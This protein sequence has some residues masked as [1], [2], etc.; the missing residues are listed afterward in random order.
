MRTF[1]F[2][3]S[4]L[5]VTVEQPDNTDELFD[6]L[7]QK[8]SDDPNVL[9]ERIP[10]WA[11]IWPSSVG[12]SE[13]IADNGDLVNGKT[14]LEIGCGPGLPGIVAA[15]R[16]GIVELTDYMQEAIDL[17]SH[18]WSLNFSTQAKTSL[19]DWRS[20]GNVKADVILASDVAYESRSFVPLL[21]ALKSLVNPGGIV[22]LSEP[23]RKFTGA[24]FTALANEGF[25]YS[26]NRRKVSKDGIEY[27]VS[28]YLII[29]K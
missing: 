13:F 27:T 7:L 18:N 17:A 23:N 19:L 2:K 29:K 1:H 26:E 25:S 20:T 22:L 6:Q 11:E 10:Y 12:L 21:N 28:V 8:G 15:L 3:F 9:D 5:D 16:G 24:F 14:V 4:G